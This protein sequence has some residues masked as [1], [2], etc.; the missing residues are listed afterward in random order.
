MSNPGQKCYLFEL[1]RHVVHKPWGRS[2]TPTS[3]DAK[4]DA[5][6]VGEIWYDDPS[7][8]DP[9]LLVKRLFTSERLSIQVHPDDKAARARGFARGK[10][11]AWLILTAEPGAS[12]ALGPKW[13]VTA[14]QLRT[15]ALDGSIEELMDWRPVRAGDFIFSPAGTIHAIGAGIQLI[16]VQ[17]NLDLTYRLYDYGRPRELH[18][19]EGIAVA[20]LSP[21]V[22]DGSASA[23]ESRKV[24]VRRPSF[25]IERWRAPFRGSA[26]VQSGCS[27]L[28]IPLAGAARAGG[29]IL[30]PGT[31]W[32]LA[33]RIGLEMDRD[34][35]LLAAYV[36]PGIAVDLL[37]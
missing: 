18:L 16:E 12:I 25:V 3:A 21:F 33:G 13:P 6:P 27:V 31:V 32:K 11:E 5:E 2:G 7:D 28:L 23:V 17:Q 26:E 15:A 22:D 20:S 9:D 10:D 30:K 29:T 14:E 36:G 8:P 35:E 1:G 34:S 19:A 24:L 37:S 4:A